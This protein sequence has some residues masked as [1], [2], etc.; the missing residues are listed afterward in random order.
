MAMKRYAAIFVVLLARLALAVD[1]EGVQPAALDQPRVHIHLRRDP[2]GEPLTAG[3]GAERTIDVEAF[4]DTGA[5]GVMLSKTTADALGVKRAVDS[6]GVNVVFM[7]VGVGGGD[8]FNVS[9]PLHVF[10]APFGRN[11]EPG[12]ADGYPIRVGPLRAQVGPLSSGIMQMLTGGLDVVGMPVINGHVAVFDPRPV[13]KFDDTMRAGLYEKNSPA[14]PK[15]DRHVKLIAKSF[16]RFT[17]LQPPEATG[18]TLADN[19]FIDGVVVSLGGKK[20][21][22]IWLL[23]TGAAAS[24]ISGAQ[25]KK[26]GVSYVEGTEGTDSPKLS[27]VQEKDQITLTVGGVGGTHKAAGFFLDTLVLPTREGD[28]IVYKPAPVFVTDI[29]VEDFKTKEKVTLDGVF[30]MNFLVASALLSE[31]GLLP[32]IGKMTAGAYDAVVVDQPGG[33]LGLKLKKEFAGAANPGKGT[34]EIKRT[35]P[36]SQVPNKH[37]R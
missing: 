33:E 1:I 13:D 18:P 37:P 17:R 28:P 9:E 2:R 23:D 14:I 35:N 16:A 10:I 22:G 20:S 24:M 29:T 4:L 15:T 31:G 34:I 11:G 30:G 32:D 25:A 19:P 21:T 7:D 36:K 26:L 3:K 6:R 5:S 27:G 8:K 12:D